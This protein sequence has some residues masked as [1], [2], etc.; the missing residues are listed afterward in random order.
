MKIRYGK[1]VFVWPILAFIL[2]IALIMMLFPSIKELIELLYSKMF[3]FSFIAGTAGLYYYWKL[4]G[5][6]ITLNDQHITWSKNK[7]FIQLKWEE[8]LEAQVR[9]LRPDGGKFLI[10]LRGA[11]AEIVIG[12]DTDN[13][14]DVIQFIKSKLGSKVDTTEIPIEYKYK[15]MRIKNWL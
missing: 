6:V 15:Q 14:I 4:M 8:I 11:D 2:G 9:I 12:S 1:K 7:E 13:V 10:R 5:T 3:Y